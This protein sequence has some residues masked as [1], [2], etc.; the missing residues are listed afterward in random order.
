MNSY[1]IRLDYFKQGDDLSFFLERDKN[2]CSALTQHAEML[3]NS[4]KT[5]EDISSIVS[6]YDVSLVKIEADCHII[7]IDGPE[8]MLKELEAKSLI[9][10]NEF[11]DDDCEEDEDEDE[12]DKD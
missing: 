10:P 9:F 2:V 5:L 1:D 6:K 8:E 4:V 7:S 11:D 3:K 12:E